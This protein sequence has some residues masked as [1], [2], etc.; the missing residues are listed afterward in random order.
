M[1]LEIGC[2][3]GE[4]LNQMPHNGLGVGLDIRQNCLQCAK[5]KFPLLSFIKSD[6]NPMP[7]KNDVFDLVFQF[8]TFSSIKNGS[9]KKAIAVEAIRVLK[10]GGLFLWY[11]FRYP[12]PLNPFTTYESRR[13]IRGY[14]NGN[15]VHLDT[16]T[17]IPQI[18]R[19]LYQKNPSAYKALDKI[20]LLHSHYF[21]YFIKDA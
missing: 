12:N 18:G 13:R 5:N 16:M 4:S 20:H 14:F 21:G 19:L 10:P 17:M 8:V 2:A 3:Q 7:F 6:S 11:D 15:K 1:V 9:I